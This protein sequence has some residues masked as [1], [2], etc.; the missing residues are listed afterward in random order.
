M[1]LN[2]EAFEIERLGCVGHGAGNHVRKGC[3]HGRFPHPECDRVAC[4]FVDPPSR[5]CRAAL[6]DF[7]VEMREQV[8]P[9]GRQEA[10]I[11]QNLR[12]LLAED[13]KAVRPVESV[14]LAAIGLSTALPSEMFDE[15]RMA[16]GIDPI[17]HLRISRIDITR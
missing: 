10:S 5:R 8:R 7:G 15:V 9:G 13:V 2:K 14:A 1:Q 17:R 11:S 16:K 12:A 6:Q 4:P 3:R